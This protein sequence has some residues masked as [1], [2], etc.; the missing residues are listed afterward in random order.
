MPS[1]AN[2]RQPTIRSTAGT[3]P[4]PSAWD[5]AAS[6]SRLASRAAATSRVACVTERPRASAFDDH[7]DPWTELIKSWHSHKVV[8]NALAI[9]HYLAGHSVTA[10]LLPVPSPPA[11]PWTRPLPAGPRHCRRPRQQ[12]AHR[13]QHHRAASRRR[14]SRAPARGRGRRKPPG[15]GRRLPAGRLLPALRRRGG[16][17]ARPLPGGPGTRGAEWRRGPAAARRA[18][19]AAA[20]SAA[21][22]VAL[23]GSPGT[24]ARRGG[25][26][27]ARR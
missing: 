4:G 14:H 18:Q 20:G 2:W 12:R 8:M 26:A 22:S 19:G 5:R 17:T 3:S 23:K 6:S 13:L 16:R 27:P 25:G 15:A 21:A 9:S 7:H 11:C 1:A 24:G 10:R